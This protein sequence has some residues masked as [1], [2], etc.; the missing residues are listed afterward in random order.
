MTIATSAL[1]LK[2]LS[3]LQLVNLCVGILGIQ[4]AWSMQIALSSQ[5]LEPLGANPF[6]FGLIW[7]AGP[8]TGLLVQP[9]VGALSDKSWTKLGRRRPFILAGALL[10]SVAMLFFPFSPTLLIAALLIWVID[11]CVN[12]SQGPYRALIPD[13]V[14]PE[15]QAVA[16]GYMNFAFGA[17]SV[18]SL[19]LAPLLRLFNV[20][21]SIT[22]QYTMA[23]L[24]LL[25]LI[26]YTSLTIKEASKPTAVADPQHVADNQ[27]PV[28]KGL[29]NS[30]LHAGPE[31]HKLC[32]V[33]FLTWVGVMCM[34]IYLT[35][36]VVHQVYQIPDLSTPAFKHIETLDSTLTPWFNRLASEALPV[37]DNTAE[38]KTILGTS[39]T[40]AKAT[41]KVLTQLQTT[42]TQL[43][44]T[45]Q[46]N[47]PLQALVQRWAA[48]PETLGISQLRA[49]SAKQ[50][51]VLQ[52]DI[53]AETQ[54]YQTSYNVL[55]LGLSPTVTEPQEV[56]LSSALTR[57]AFTDPE[58]LGLE[59]L[60]LATM[61]TAPA[62]TNQNTDALAQ[63]RQFITQLAPQLQAPPSAMVSN[64]S[65]ASPT[66]ATLTP[67]QATV[68]TKAKALW[69]LKNKV[70]YQQALATAVLTRTSGKVVNPTKPA[71][72]FATLSPYQSLEPST[73]IDSMGVYQQVQQLKG[74]KTLQSEAVNTT[75]LALVA[76][77]VMPLLLS[78]PLGY[79]CNMVGKKPVYTVTLSFLAVAFA[80]APWVQT[81]WQAI[82][83]MACAGVAW[84]TILSIPFAFLAEALPPGEE[85]SMMGIFNMFVAGPQLISATVVSWVIMQSP[86]PT[87]F[88][89]SHNWSIAF[90]VAS[91]FTFGAIAMLQTLKEGRLGLGST[92]TL[93]GGGTLVCLRYSGLARGY[94]QVEIFPYRASTC[95]L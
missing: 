37:A 27:R 53:E 8:I 15:Q 75:Q 23:A 39:A 7:C 21:V 19:G 41:E 81:P 25:L 89:M 36:L 83:M 52:S 35:P 30:F 76:L 50:L 65:L 14:P 22:Q 79:L 6:I 90:V 71:V 60:K 85:G 68:A 1:G 51:A 40:D 74:F 66:N 58:A 80:F 73:S 63:R 20:S 56:V 9:I 11:A 13:I 88:G 54:L 64:T 93:A 2:R 78:I 55:H 67:L 91:V 47:Q 82:G 42:L 84:S 31:L 24:A 61:G 18:I 92:T 5:V 70:S 59:R 77:N 95:Y 3:T 94:S 44:T 87:M 48:N 62:L 33:Q 10:G 57:L 4:F 45:L 26:I 32:A 28:K 69:V 29:F 43:Q 38:G 46:P 17:G 34:F 16:N 72:A 86:L 12:I 49:L